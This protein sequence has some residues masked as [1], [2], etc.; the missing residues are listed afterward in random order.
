M[1]LRL[2]TR[3][4]ISPVIGAVLNIPI[5]FEVCTQYL[6]SG[7]GPCNHALLIPTTNH[8]HLVTI[9]NLPMNIVPTSKCEE[10]VCEISVSTT[11]TLNSK[12]HVGLIPV[13]FLRN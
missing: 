9:T 5:K 1:K 6:T 10:I 8:S 2:T 13:Q 11:S 4:H 12:G 7:N 3:K